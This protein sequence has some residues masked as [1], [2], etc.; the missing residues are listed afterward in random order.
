MQRHLDRPLTTGEIAA[1][2]GTPERS[3]RRQFQRF[4]GQSLIAYHRALRLEAARHALCDS[5]TKT[6]VTTIAN[7]H[8]FSHLSHFTSQYRQRYGELPST[9]LREVVDGPLPRRTHPLGDPIKLIVLPFTS[10]GADPSEAPLAETTTDRVISA[11]TRTRWLNVLS[12]ESDLSAD[13]I[14]MASSGAQYAVRGRV[15]SVRGHVQTVVRL[16]EL[17]TG[18]QI[19]GN[20]FQGTA[21]GA[22]ELQERMTEA[23]A[24]ALPASLRD[25][26]AT[27]AKRKPERD[28]VAVHCTR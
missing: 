27:R 13:K 9:T 19:W 16:I 2:A 26:R 14:R 4:I 10:T 22:V 11:L 21:E 7:G 23:V 1:A 8:G 25:A 20:A 28:C 6:D 12:P 24:S 17:A 3:L 5:Q 18:R 15:E